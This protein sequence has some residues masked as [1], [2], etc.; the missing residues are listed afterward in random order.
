MTTNMII[1]FMTFWKYLRLPEEWTRHGIGRV[2]IRDSA[3]SLSAISGEE[4]C[5]AL[6]WSDAEIDRSVIMLFLTLCSLQV[7]K[8]S[9]SSNMTY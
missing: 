1:F 4:N 7:I 9:L 5:G 8:S 6:C 3:F 2:V